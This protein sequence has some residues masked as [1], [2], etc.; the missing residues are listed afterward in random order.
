MAQ[1]TRNDIMTKFESLYLP[2]THKTFTF[3]SDANGEVTRSEIQEQNLISDEV[4]VMLECLVDAILTKIKD[5][6][7]DMGDSK[8]TK[9]DVQ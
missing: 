9:L 6:G 3:S 4:R 8:A 5:N 1:V 7:I 2:K